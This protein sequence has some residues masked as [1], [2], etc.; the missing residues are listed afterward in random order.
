M[1]RQGLVRV[2]RAC[3][4]IAATAVL[5]VPASADAKY[6]KRTLRQGSQGSDVKL[7]QKYLVKAGFKTKATGYYGSMTAAAEKRFERARGRRADGK[8]TRK[9]QRLVRKVARVRAAHSGG[10]GGTGGS[11]YEPTQDNPTGKARLSSDG[12]TAIAPAGA[13]PA[14]K[15]AIAAANRITRKPYKWGGGHGRWEDTGYDCSGSVS[16]AMHGAGILKRPRDSTGFMSW[17][18]PGKGRWITVYANAGHA[19]TVIAGLRFDT[20]AAGA[21]GGSGPRWRTKPRSSSGYTVRH[22][23]R[24]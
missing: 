17:G 13:P 3:V 24:F 6:A 5:L 21:G 18:K 11:G 7:F 14:V 22:P 12:R 8:A 20:S 23:T 19:Y 10:T 4:A 16:Y 9:D 1:A 15:K 2:M